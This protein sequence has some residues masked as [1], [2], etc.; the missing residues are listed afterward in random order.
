MKAIKVLVSSSI[1]EEILTTGYI[2]GDDRMFK[3]KQ[4]LPPESKLVSIR[5]YDMQPDTIEFVFK[6][7]IFEDLRAVPHLDVV[8]ESILT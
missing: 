4:G 8:V 2:I 3:I 7:E 5:W 1:I 6:N